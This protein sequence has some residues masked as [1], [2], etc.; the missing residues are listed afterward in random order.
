MHPGAIRSLLADH[1]IGCQ[2]VTVAE[3]GGL[4]IYLNPG[5]GTALFAEAIL[6]TH[7][8]TMNV[9]RP[10]VDH[11]RVYCKPAL[12]IITMAPFL[13]PKPQPHQQESR[14]LLP[15]LRNRPER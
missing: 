7:P 8:D 14:R 9:T 6:N 1:A 11:L 13:Q 3:D 12:P 10:G 4:N 5:T 2:A 15:W